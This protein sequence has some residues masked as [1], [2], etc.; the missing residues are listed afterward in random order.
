MVESLKG[1]HQQQMKTIER[2]SFP[3]TGFL[4]GML[5]S[6]ISRSSAGQTLTQLAGEDPVLDSDD[7]VRKLVHVP[8]PA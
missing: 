2:I 4:K 6:D 1:R 8:N 7:V 5:P 3:L